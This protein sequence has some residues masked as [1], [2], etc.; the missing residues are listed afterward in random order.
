[1]A[2]GS[3]ILVSLLR[4]ARLG[5]VSLAARAHPLLHV[6]LALAALSAGCDEECH[7]GERSYVKGDTWTC[8]DGCNTCSCVGD[9][10]IQKT[11]IGCV[12]EPGP[13]AGK[14]HCSEGKASYR[15]GTSWECAKSSDS[16][17]TLC[18]CDDG[19]IEEVACTE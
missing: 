13:A 6:C 18:S 19:D 7:E 12:D 15:H 10:Q 9:D 5:A 1:M 4:T 11:L 8:S 14:L 3:N 2:L 16:E 17:C